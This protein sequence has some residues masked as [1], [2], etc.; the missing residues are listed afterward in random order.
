MKKLLVLA[1]I[2]SLLAA[3]ALFA[4]EKKQSEKDSK[5]QITAKIE[6]MK[7]AGAS[8]EEINVV[9]ADYKKKVAAKEAQAKETA[10]LKAELKKKVAE[11]NAAGA[12]EEEIKKMVTEFK[13]KVEA[14]NKKAEK[15]KAA[16]KKTKVTI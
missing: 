3:A 9:I 7:Q 6:K 8:E 11:I 2:V 10:K 4:G 1:L 12:S 13:K 14:K 5:A 16:K 15:E